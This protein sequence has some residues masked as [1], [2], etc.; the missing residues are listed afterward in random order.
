MK[1][2]RAA[3]TVGAGAA[4]PAVALAKLRSQHEELLRA[5]SHDLRTPL[6]ALL[7]QAQLLERSL[8]HRDPNQRRAATIIAMTHEFTAIIDRLVETA[9]L[10]AGIAK[11]D[12]E[13]VALPELLRDLVSQLPPTEGSR[14]VLTVDD[15]FP[16]IVLDRCRIQTVIKT[17]LQRATRAS[18]GRIGVSLSRCGEELRLA[19]RDQ[20]PPAAPLARSLAAE[21]GATYDSIYL[22][23]VIV[24]AHGGRLW[25]ET[26]TDQGNTAIF[27][28]PLS[29]E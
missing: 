5:M 1:N 12:T 28:L 13:S 10:E 25:F 19:V 11:L 16:D 4:A 15:A 20:G 8:D 14:V 26:A 6:V 23:K 18:P 17:L 24:E 3:P 9:R 2:D 22:A 7:L 27:A 29:S 21:T